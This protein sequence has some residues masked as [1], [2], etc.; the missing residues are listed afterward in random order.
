M[1]LEQIIVLAKEH[2]D[3]RAEE[4]KKEV[5]ERLDAQAE[6]LK[7]QMNN[8]A[9]LGV[10][11]D[12]ISS[13]LEQGAK[14]W[15]SKTVGIPYADALILQCRSR[16]LFIG[17]RGGESHFRLPPGAY[18]VIVMAFPQEAKLDAKGCF[19]DEYGNQ[20][21]FDRDC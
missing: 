9:S 13:L 8:M 4:L 16:N 12:L 6:G 14:I 2:I 11:Q 7:S 1:G 10:S 3:R 15:V 20:V 18:R 5:C 17:E 21:T 19:Q